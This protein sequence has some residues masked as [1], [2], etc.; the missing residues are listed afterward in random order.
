MFFVMV[1]NTGS[2][3]ADPL[4][5]WRDFHIPNY[6]KTGLFSRRGCIVRQSCK[7]NG[8]TTHNCH[9]SRQIC[10]PWSYAG[11]NGALFNGRNPE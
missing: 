5:F 7:A 8:L 10:I 6:Q 2:N 11:K 9:A 3:P 4:G 1:Q